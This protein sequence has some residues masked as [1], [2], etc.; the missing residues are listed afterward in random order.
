VIYNFSLWENK[1]N[2]TR[3]DALPLR[4][5][6]KVLSLKQK[7]DIKMGFFSSRPKLDYSGDVHLLIEQ[8]TELEDQKALVW[9]SKNE[10]ND[11]LREI[12]V[13]KLN[14]MKWEKLLIKIA[15][16][17]KDFQVQLAAFNNL[18]KHVCTMSNQ[19]RLIR[20]AKNGFGIGERDSF[21]RE[22]AEKRLEL[23]NGKTKQAQKSKSNSAVLGGILMQCP[24][25]REDFTPPHWDRNSPMKCPYCGHQWRWV[26]E[27]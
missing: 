1:K 15:K 16:K 11:V 17:D 13:T 9:L 21:I 20:I 26:V 18:E 19:N 23:L 14:P 25:C 10:T 8:V 3:M 24:H 22:A 6:S 7:E 2:T 5:K 27:K 12:A 4:V